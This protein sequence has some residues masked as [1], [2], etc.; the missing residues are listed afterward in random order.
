M[1]ALPIPRSN[2]AAVE[3]MVTGKCDVCG[4]VSKHSYALADKIWSTIL[5]RALTSM[6]MMAGMANLAIRLP[7][8]AVPRGFSAWAALV[9]FFNVFSF[10]SCLQ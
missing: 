9:W 7:T 8:G 6:L 5:Y 10:L 4:G 1:E 2:A 3:I